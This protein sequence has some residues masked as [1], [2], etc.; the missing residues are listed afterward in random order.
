[1]VRQLILVLVMLGACGGPSTSPAPTPQVVAARAVA[2]DA[3]LE[4]ART[5]VT[6]TSGGRTIP[7]T[8]VAPVEPGPWP[9]IVLLA[10]S[11]PTNRDWNSPLLPAQHG[12]GRLLAERLARHGAV[13]LRFDKAGS[14]QNPGPPIAEWTLDTYLDET[15]AALALV[16]ARPDVRRDR[17]F[18]AGHS[19]GG[20][21]ATRLAA[22][23]PAEI[24]GVLYLASAA[25]SM[26]DTM[27]TQIRNQ[28]D[29]P[30]ALLSDAEVE[31]EMTSL[32]AA[33]ADILAARPVDVA[34]VSKIPQLQGLIAAL[35][36]P[37]AARL[38]AGLLGYDNL[39]EAPK[40]A[41]PMLVISGG[42]DIQIDPELDTRRLADALRA[43][44]RDLT[45]HIAADADHV[46]KH[47]PRTIAALRANLVAVQNG[48]NAEGRTL[49][50]DAVRAI[51]AWLATHSR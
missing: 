46:L 32:R 48:Y 27:L 34:K 40:L 22:A 14:G 51:V 39:A 30:I 9:A 41:V 15:R 29:N 50:A 12:S 26:A 21:H 49:D 11:G 5:E 37:A 16:R 7:G 8:I 17:V 42:K 28:L 24:A 25:R 1:M 10:G 18:V 23:A 13:V 6:F 35:A 19:E 43:A 20:I 33:M 45:L 36:A 2:V 4:I 3:A 31:A 38:T 44:N 47:E